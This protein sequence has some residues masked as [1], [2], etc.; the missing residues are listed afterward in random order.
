MELA[1]CC[2]FLVCVDGISRLDQARPTHPGMAEILIGWGWIE[3]RYVSGRAG[4]VLGRVHGNVGLGWV[5]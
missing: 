3:L 5:G 2:L 4:I 1:Q